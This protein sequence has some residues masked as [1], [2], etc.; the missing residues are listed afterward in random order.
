[1]S[2]STVCSG[3]IPL[4]DLDIRTNIVVYAFCSHCD[5]RTPNAPTIVAL[6]DSLSLLMEDLFYNQICL[7][8]DLISNP[9]VGN[10]SI[11]VYPNVSVETN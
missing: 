2:I 11:C 3:I 6:L 10:V 9:Q 5:R 4:T 8:L 1:M 7:G